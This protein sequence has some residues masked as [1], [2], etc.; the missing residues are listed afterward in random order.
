MTVELPLITWPIQMIG[1]TFKPNSLADSPARGRPEG[2]QR[3]A[4]L[5]PRDFEETTLTPPATDSNR[6]VDSYRRVVRSPGTIQLA[7]SRL[8]KTF[9]ETVSVDV[10]SNI[11]TYRCRS[12]TQ[13]GGG[14]LVIAYTPL[15]LS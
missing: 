13:A 4:L 2:G 15:R 1:T 7:R 11:I 3:E 14:D 10:E 8:R 12:E 6:P 5:T 9:E